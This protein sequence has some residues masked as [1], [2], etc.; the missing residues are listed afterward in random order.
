[1]SSM[2]GVLYMSGKAREGQQERETLI[3]RREV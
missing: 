1:M 3:I 2:S